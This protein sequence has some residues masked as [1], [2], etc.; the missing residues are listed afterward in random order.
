MWNIDKLG[1]TFRTRY[2]GENGKSSKQTQI[3]WNETQKFVGTRMIMNVM[4]PDGAL[5]E[6]RQSCE[7]QIY[8]FHLVLAQ[9]CMWFQLHFKLQIP[10]HL[11]E[12]AVKWI[13]TNSAV[14]PT[15]FA[16]I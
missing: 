14:S 3:H 6:C 15:P 16:C 10:V 12:H 1:E 8:N 4:W 11:Q 9:Q 5:D 2:T 13:L 7:R